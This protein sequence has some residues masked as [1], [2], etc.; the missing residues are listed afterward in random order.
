[1]KRLL[2][3]RDHFGFFMRAANRTNKVNNGRR[4]FKSR[5]ENRTHYQ[6]PES[7]ATCRLVTLDLHLMHK[8]FGEH[9]MVLL[10][11]G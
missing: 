8:L 2:P 1:M 9:P 5:G 3:A 6:I 10:L 4:G 7:F 11:F